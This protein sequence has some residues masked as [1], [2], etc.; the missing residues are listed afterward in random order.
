MQPLTIIYTTF[1]ELDIIERSLASVA[2]WTDDLLVVDSFSTDGT[3]ELLERLPG[4]TLTQRAYAGPADQKNWAIARAKYEWVLLL[5]ADEIV[6]PELREEITRMME[7]PDALLDAYWIGRDNFFMGRRIR[8]SGWSGDEVVRFFHRDRCRYDD[9]QVHEEIEVSGLRVGRLRGRLEHF[10]F[11]NLDHF[12]DK[13]RRYA[14]WSAQD[15]APRTQRVGL[16]HLLLKPVFRFV[17]HYLIKG[18]FRDGREGLIISMV[19]AYG[20]FLRYA[21]M[22]AARRK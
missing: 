17:K 20:V 13:I 5:D 18:G 21:Y 2:D 15:Y 8:H 7:S 11:K 19:L 14:R 10:T 3:A 16:Y 22:L 1:N 6:T 4:V 12:L 9:K